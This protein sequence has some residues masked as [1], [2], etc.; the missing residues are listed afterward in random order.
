MEPSETTTSTSPDGDHAPETRLTTR[1][2]RLW[3]IDVPVIGAPMAGRAGG[4]LAA[5]VT[6]AGGLG[7]IG[8]GASTGPDWIAENAA[9]AAAAGPFGIGL[10]VWNLAD[11]PEQWRATLDARP[12]VV[13]LAFGDPTPYVEEAHEHG[14]SV[15]APVNDR[16]QLLQA[17]AAGVDVVCVQGTDAGGHTGR[18]GTMPWMQQVLTYLAV[19][20]PG[21]PVAVAGGVASGR[22][23]AAVLA[24]GADAAWVGT[25]F[26]A[27]P[28]ALGDEA[29][30]AAAE[31]ADGTQT[32]L[33]DVYDRAEGLAWDT[34]TWPTRTVVTDFVS[35]YT[36]DPTVTDDE[37]AAALAPGGEYDDTLKLHAGQ[38]I[39]LVKSREPA[40][41]IVRRFGEEA[42]ALLRRTF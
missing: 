23:L 15:V 38:G 24:A 2:T 8:V 25:S 31:K 36:G 40:G 30:R 27:S 22:G 39:G 18:L 26:L 34:E 16:T 29:L 11:H 19:T 20:A 1:L 7:M 12:T 14:V 21:V 9:T 35:R 42:A 10:M 5:A 33:T 32:V 28:E 3:G 41:D 6:A 37:L 17:L 4:D 13:S